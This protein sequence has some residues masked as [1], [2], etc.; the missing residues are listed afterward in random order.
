MNDLQI[1]STLT[2]AVGTIDLVIAQLGRC[3][4]GDSRDLIARTRVDLKSAS[5]EL[6]LLRARLCGDK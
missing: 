4:H 5:A 1:R 2:S 6:L 3:E